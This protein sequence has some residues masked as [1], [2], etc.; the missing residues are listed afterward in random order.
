VDGQEVVGG[1]DD[2][3]PEGPQAVRGLVGRRVR[4]DVA[5]QREDDGLPS[6][7]NDREA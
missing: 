2:S 1:D 4:L 6:A 3:D 5:A 7:W